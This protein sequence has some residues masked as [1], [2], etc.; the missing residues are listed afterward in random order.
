MNSLLLLIF[1]CHGW[2][3]AI[4]SV[5]QLFLLFWFARP[6]H[7][8]VTLDILK[9]QGNFYG[10]WL[11]QVISNNAFGNLVNWFHLTVWSHLMSQCFYQCHLLEVLRNAWFCPMNFNVVLV[12]IN[13]SL[14][15]KGLHK[16]IKNTNTLRF[17]NLL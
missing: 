2:H 13:I 8:W 5:R 6:C 17:S 3:H 10:G 15:F 9:L 4:A 12:M 11:C 14:Q 16:T 1:Y 7:R